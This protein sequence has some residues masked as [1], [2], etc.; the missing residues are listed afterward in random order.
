MYTHVGIP[1]VEYYAILS[2]PCYQ[3][4]L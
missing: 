3:Y 1:L 2:H 4:R